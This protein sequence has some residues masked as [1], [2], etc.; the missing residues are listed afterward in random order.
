MVLDLKKQKDYFGKS[1]V[2]QSKSK[3]INVT[4]IESIAPFK[5]ES[6]DYVKH[7]NRESSINKNINASQLKGI[8]KKMRSEH[9][10]R[11][12]ERYGQINQV[13]EKTEQS[14]EEIDQFK[15]TNERDKEMLQTG[16]KEAHKYVE[17]KKPKF[18]PKDM[19]YK[20]YHYENV[21]HA[22]KIYS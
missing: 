8:V 22:E 14:Q 9:K 18:N 11:L 19:T 12:Q 10:S 21:K 5:N 4:T 15:D 6:I 16:L 13:T 2:D 3:F 1:R 7:A 20:K 17:S